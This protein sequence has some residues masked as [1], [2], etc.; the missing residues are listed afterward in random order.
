MVYF[1][2]HPHGS[3]NTHQAPICRTDGFVEMATN[4]NACTGGSHMIQDVASCRNAAELKGYK[5]QKALTSHY[6]PQG[7]LHWTVYNVVYLNKAAPGKPQG[8]SAPLCCKN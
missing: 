2:P 5:F 7:C 4:T 3:T 8:W 6:F 1:N